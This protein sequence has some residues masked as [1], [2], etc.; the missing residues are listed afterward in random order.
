M[1]GI[2]LQRRFAIALEKREAFVPTLA[3]PTD[4][5]RIIHS[6]GDGFPGITV[7]R[8]GR[9]LLVEAHTNAI[10]IEPLLSFLIEKHADMPIFLKRKYA[11]DPEMRHGI[12]VAGVPVSPLIVVHEEG[13][14]FHINLTGGPHIGLFLDSRAVRRRVRNISKN[15]RVLNLFSYTGGFGVAAASG[16]ARSTTNIDQKRSALNG[17]RAN[18]E[19]NG[20]Q[21]DGRTFLKSDAKAY[22]KKVSKQGH[23]YDLIILDPPPAAKRT[24]RMGFDTRNDYDKWVAMSLSVLSESGYLVAGLNNPKVSNE[25]FI[26]MARQGVVLADIESV[27]IEHILVDADFPET[28][29]RPTARF[30]Q[31][32]I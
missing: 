14:K 21:T 7:D 32:T 4:A 9:V 31:L 29:T 8:L 5:F 18:Y 28:P 26:D 10:E 12:Q 23:R 3:S 20:V 16:G 19:L 1:N 6:D 25:A 27:T 24:N 2:S 13:M 15:R 22:L 11:K 30:V 17:A